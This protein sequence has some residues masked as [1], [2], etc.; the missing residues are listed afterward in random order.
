MEQGSP[1][2]TIFKRR[3]RRRELH[4][5]KLLSFTPEETAPKRIDALDDEICTVETELERLD[6]DNYTKFRNQDSLFAVRAALITVLPVP[7]RER[8]AADLWGELGF[9]KKLVI[10]DGVPFLHDAL[11]ATPRSE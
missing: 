2:L 6:H 4:L 5:T 11:P 3:Q 10:A 7:G 1:E 9:Y 8:V